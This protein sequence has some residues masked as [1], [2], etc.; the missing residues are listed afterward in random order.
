MGEAE[1]DG[2]MVRVAMIRGVS[3]IV[4]A[5][6]ATVIVAHAEDS[7]MKFASMANVDSS[8]IQTC[9]TNVRASDLV[10]HADQWTRVTVMVTTT[11]GSVP[12]YLTAQAYT[13]ELS[14]WSVILVSADSCVVRMG[15]TQLVYTG[16]SNLHARLKRTAT[17]A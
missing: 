16:N 12:Q 8:V 9:P 5:Q 6:M 15:T 11:V 10:T 1:V 17:I 7:L 14:I 3:G 4:L 2:A 13:Q